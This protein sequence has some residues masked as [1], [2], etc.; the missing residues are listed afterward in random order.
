MATNPVL[1]V[2]FWP[3]IP[4]FGDESRSRRHFLAGNPI[5]WRRIPFS[6]PF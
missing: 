1:V 3:E 4:F 2:I 6:S 5:F